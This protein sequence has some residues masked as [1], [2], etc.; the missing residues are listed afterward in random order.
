MARANGMTLDPQGRPCY[1]GEWAA[2]WDAVMRGVEPAESLPSAVR[3]ALFRTLRAE[4]LTDTEVATWTRST[5]HVVQR[6]IG[7]VDRVHDP[8][9]LDQTAIRPPLATGRRDHVRSRP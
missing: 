1:V 3:A 8:R 2:V 7:T 5:V 9:S 4:G 6:Q